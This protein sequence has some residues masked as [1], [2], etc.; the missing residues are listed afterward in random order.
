[1]LETVLLVRY[2]F[3]DWIAWFLALLALGI[4]LFISA[5]KV[6]S[7]R[8]E[9][10]LLGLF[11]VSSIFWLASVGIPSSLAYPWNLTTFGPAVGPELPLRNA[12]TFFSGFRNL[13]NIEDI[14]KAIQGAEKFVL[15]QFV[16]KNAWHDD[17]KDSKAYTKS[18]LDE[19]KTIADK[20]AKKTIIRGA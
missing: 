15:Q 7:T 12:L 18:E 14:A 11:A 10:F 6:C 8:M 5:R 17:V 16:S 4:I 19:F 9:L 3:F 2:F 13:P 1:M 20:Y